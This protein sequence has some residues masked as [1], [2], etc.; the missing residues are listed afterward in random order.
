VACPGPQLYDYAL[1]YI[2]PLLEGIPGVAS[3]SITAAANGR[4]TSSVDPT[5]AQAR[6]LTPPMWPVRSRSPCVA[7]LR[8]AHLAQIRRQRLHQCGCRAGRRH[9]RRGGEVAQ[10]PSCV[11]FVMWPRWK[12]AVRRRRRPWPSMGTT[13]SIST[14]CGIPGRQR[15]RPSVAAVKRPSAGLTNLPSGVE[16]PAH[17]RTKIHL[18]VAHELF[19]G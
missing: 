14:F 12:M 16:G 7:A 11:D 10:E 5:R 8:R 4:S 9:R 18:R 2:E 17:F 1:N 19:G 15:A 6:G 3:A 13:R